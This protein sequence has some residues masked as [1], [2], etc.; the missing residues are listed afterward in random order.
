MGG[1]LRIGVLRNVRERLI[2]WSVRKQYFGFSRRPAAISTNK[3]SRGDATSW[4]SRALKSHAFGVRHAIRPMHTLTRH[5]SYF[6]CREITRIAPTNLR[7]Y[8]TVEQVGIKWVPLT[9]GDQTSS[10]AQTCPLFETLLKINVSGRNF[11]IVRDF[12]KA[13]YMF[14]LNLLC[15]SLGRSQTSEATPSPT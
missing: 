12:I 13:S 6:S 1:V 10:F 8:L 9:K 15:V 3:Q 14:T 4:G 2:Y 11:K 7:H 5:T